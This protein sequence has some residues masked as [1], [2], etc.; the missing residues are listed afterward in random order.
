[1][2]E[3]DETD[4]KILRLLMDDARRSYKDIGEHVGLSSP[5]VSNRIDRLK[6]LGVIEGFTVNIDRSALKTGDDI[7]IEIEAQPGNAEDI[8]DTLTDVSSVECIL[9]S[10]DPRITVHAYMDDA[11]LERL[12]SHTLDQQWL[13]GYEVRKITRSIW[14]P[15]VDRADL[16]IECVECGKAVRGEG[17]T[18]E[19]DDKRYYLCCT[20]CESLFQEK[21]DRLEGKSD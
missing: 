6:E 8:V 13:K 10:I 17:V 1:M 14:R 9:Q 20:S 18:V 15:Q 19:V 7:L 21:Y 5:S 12:F 4:T 11:E 16:A 3:L 2:V